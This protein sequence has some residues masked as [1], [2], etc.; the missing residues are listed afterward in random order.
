[1]FGGPPYT[2]TTTPLRDISD[3]T[4]G[5]QRVWSEG[6]GLTLQYHVNEHLTLKSITGLTAYDRHDP[7]GYGPNDLR[8]LAL[9]AGGVALTSFD[10]LYS[11]QDRG[12]GVR[13]RSEELQALG[14]VGDFDYVGGFYY[15][16]ENRRHRP[17]R[18]QRDQDLVRLPAPVERRPVQ[19]AR[20]VRRPGPRRAAERRLLVQVGRRLGAA[21]RQPHRELQ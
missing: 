14:S 9:G 12:Q 10:G 2:V 15:Y 13:A 11:L 3:A 5:E 6:I 8:G 16:D 1:V 21:V 18:E 19:R 4:R 17:A 7:S 20:P